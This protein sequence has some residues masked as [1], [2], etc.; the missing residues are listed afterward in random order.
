M[1]SL[2]PQYVLDLHLIRH[3]TCM[4]FK[5]RCSMEDVKGLRDSELG[6]AHDHAHFP[7][8]EF[9]VVSNCASVGCYCCLQNRVMQVPG[10]THLMRI[11]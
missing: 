2:L 6:N 3:R 7:A 4:G 9:C 5:H 11:K 10:A 1:T 8:T